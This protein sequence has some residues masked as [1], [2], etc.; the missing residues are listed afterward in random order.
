MCNKRAR[1]V[2]D[3]CVAVVPSGVTPGVVKGALGGRRLAQGVR[4]H[5]MPP[6]SCCYVHGTGREYIPPRVCG[7]D[8]GGAAQ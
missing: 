2:R 4:G 6:R 5:R 3:K 7:G 1:L 8:E